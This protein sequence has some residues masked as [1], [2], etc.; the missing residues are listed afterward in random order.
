MSEQWVQ[1][2]IAE[3]FWLM[4]PDALH[5]FMINFGQNINLSE[6]SV[7][8][9]AMYDRYKEETSQNEAE[10]PYPVVSGIAV[11]PVKGEL[12]KQASGF[13]A[14]LFGVRGMVQI[15]AEIQAA[16]ADPDV[17]GI[18]LHIDTPGGTA[19]GTPDL[20]DI[21]FWARGQKP[22]LS[23]ADGQMTSAGQWIG[24]AAGFV[25]V[26]NEITRVGSV[27]VVGVH[28]DYADRAKEL[29]IKP[30]VFSAGKFKAKGNPYEHLSKDDRAYIQEQFDYLHQQFVD[31][32]AKNTGIPAQRL[33][34]DLK[35]ARVF[36]GSQG[37]AVGLAHR[38][39][40]Y[41]DAMA[42]LI[43]V[44]D[45]K[46]TFGANTPK[47]SNTGIQGGPDKMD[48]MEKLQQ[49]VAK[50]TQELADARATVETFQSQ[51]MEKEVSDLKGTIS[52]LEKQLADAN[53]EV[54]RLTSEKTELEKYAGVG[55]RAIDAV[56]TAIEKLSAQVEGD[57]FDKT[58]LDAQIQAFGDDYEL[59]KK[60]E[61]NLTARAKTM[62]E[63]GGKVPDNLESKEKD[64]AQQQADAYTLGTAIGKTHGNVVPLR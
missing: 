3:R 4:E 35:Q 13:L 48:D 32:V 55:R 18:F 10:K 57:G 27:G 26:A 39:M 2:V 20:A 9:S 62:F 6:S 17:K 60:F 53:A 44:A 28:F 30:T 11:I 34:A 29:G 59:L 25:A 19:D 56:K 37:I 36:M 45:G 54:D 58:L 64:A 7:V 42:L 63:T 15:G 38:V 8:D 51:N 52:A 47:T 16:A 23:F 14:W 49:Q 21:V 5:R 43:D 61:A 50:L 1:H 24:G 46:T 40:T 33:D 31:G 12:V 41:T 22:V